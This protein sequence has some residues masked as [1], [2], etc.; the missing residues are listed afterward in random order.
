MPFYQ[1]FHPP[2][3]FWLPL[4]VIWPAWEW[5]FQTSALFHSR[6]LKVL[7]RFLSLMALTQHCPCNRYPFLSTRAVP[8]R[9]SGQHRAMGT[10]KLWH[11]TNMTPPSSS[12]HIMGRLKTNINIRRIPRPVLDMTVSSTAVTRVPWRTA[13]SH[14][15]KLDRMETTLLGITLGLVGTISDALAEDWTCRI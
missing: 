5:S 12:S 13:R 8:F 6:G 15:R 3:R 9:I 11:L 4:S 2:L 10:R 7:A 14:L 1:I